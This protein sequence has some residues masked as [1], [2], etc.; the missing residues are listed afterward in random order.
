LAVETTAANASSFATYDIKLS[1]AAPAP[2]GSHQNR[3]A[4]NLD[5]DYNQIGMN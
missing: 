3:A 4:I 1:H 2:A 5:R